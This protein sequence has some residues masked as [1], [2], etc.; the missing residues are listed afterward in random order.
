[1][2]GLVRREAR[3]QAAGLSGCSGPLPGEDCL[4]PASVRLPV[5]GSR[6]PSLD[7]N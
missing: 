2:A 4:P 3:G 7:D 6:A 5:P 1:M